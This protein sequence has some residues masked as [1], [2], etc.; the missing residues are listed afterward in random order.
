M[1]QTIENAQGALDCIKGAAE[2][3]KSYITR[4]LPESD[5]RAESIQHIDLAV[6]HCEFI[7]KPKQPEPV[8]IEE[9]PKSSARDSLLAQKLR[10]IL[11]DEPEEF[12]KIM[13]A[14]E[15]GA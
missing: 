15:S 4:A 9:V 11:K 6:E 13:L 12:E 1:N 14:V 7:V 5:D 3:L 2:Q 10:H 8:Q